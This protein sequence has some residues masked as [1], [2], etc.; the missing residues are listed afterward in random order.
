MQKIAYLILPIFF[1]L[2]N[3]VET[4]LK[5]NHSSFCESAGCNFAANLLRFDALYLNF[6]GVAVSALIMI[7]GWMVIK[8]K[9]D[10]K[11]FLLLVFISLLFETVMLSYQYFASPMM[12]KFCMGIYGFLVAMML[13]ASKRYFFMVLPAVFAIITAFSFL[14]IPKTTAFTTTDGTY[15]IQ[16]PTCPHCKKVKKYFKEHDI[17]FTKLDINSPEAKNFATYLNFGTIPIMI[18]KKGHH[19]EI[20]NGDEAI[21]DSFKE[22][23]D[24]EP[25]QEQEPTPSESSISIGELPHE[26]GCGFFD[27]S[28]V[29]E[30][31]DSEE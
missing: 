31:C 4:L 6:I 15:L 13:T 20:I 25:T 10:K 18:V 2:Y 14:A 28:K 9:I 17:A 7:V 27:I 26:E 5:L 11:F 16:S 22:M 23:K 1:F 3:L 19:V 24:E 29:E 21:L 8:E 12:C 30:S